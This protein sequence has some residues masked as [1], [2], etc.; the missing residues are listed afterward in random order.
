MEAHDN[1][2]IE[3]LIPSEYCLSCKRCCRFAEQNSAW[4][5]CLLDEEAQNFIDTDIPAVSL[6]A[7]RRLMLNPNPEGE[8]FIC[9]FLNIQGNKCKIYDIRPFE[10][11]LYP[12]LIS[13]R[14]KK[15]LLTVDLNCPYIKE[16]LNNQKLKDY[17]SYLTTFLNSPALVKL[18]K[19]NPQIIQAYE[20]ILDVVELELPHET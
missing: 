14:K 18:L 9:P 16:N 1:Y 5:P 6:S 11:R 13:A 12:F 2:Y 15:V 4:S 8:G 20:D 7:Q 3:Q 19:E 17:T 10:C